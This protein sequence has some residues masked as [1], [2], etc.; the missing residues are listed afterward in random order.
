[1][2]AYLF[3][4]CFKSRYILQSIFINKTAM[5]GPNILNQILRET[6]DNDFSVDNS[7]NQKGFV[8]IFFIVNTG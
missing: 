7:G 6:T 5:N 4:C 3:N 8:T 1:M 2:L